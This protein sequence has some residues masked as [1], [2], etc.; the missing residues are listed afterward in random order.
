MATTTPFTPEQLVEMNRMVQE[1]IANALAARNS[2]TTTPTTTA[3]AED[4]WIKEAIRSDVLGT[5][6]PDY[7]SA[8]MTKSIVVE[9]GATI[10]R[11]VEIFIERIDRLI[12]LC[13][14]RA[15]VMVEQY[16]RGEA[17]VWWLHQV[18]TEERAKMKE[19]TDNCAAWKAA[20]RERFGI[21][22][23]KAQAYLA[24]TLYGPLELNA[25]K[26]VVAF[27]NERQLRLKQS[28]V[29]DPKIQLQLIWNGLLPPYRYSIAPPSATETATQFLDRL[30]QGEDSWRMAPRTQPQ[31]R[32]FIPNAGNPQ[33]FNTRAA[34][35]SN[36]VSGFTNANTRYAP[37][38]R[39]NDGYVRAYRQ[40]FSPRQGGFNR[41]GYGSNGYASSQASGRF[42][43][44]GQM[45]QQTAN[46]AQTRTY[47]PNPQAGGMKPTPTPTTT[48]PTATT[49][50]SQ[51]RAFQP[52]QRSFTNSS[53]NLN[54]LSRPYIPP[55]NNPRNGFHADEIVW[56]PEAYFAEPEDVYFTEDDVFDNQDFDGFMGEYPELETADGMQADLMPVATF[57]TPANTSR[58]S[59]TPLPSI[60]TD[61]TQ[62]SHNGELINTNI[63]SNPPEV[64][65]FSV[66]CNTAEAFL[67][68][69]FRFPLTPSL[70]S[71]PSVVANS[72]K[73]TSGK[74]LCVP[75]PTKCE[76]CELQFPSAR[77]CR[78]HK[79]IHQTE[80]H[81]RPV[82]EIQAHFAELGP[83]HPSA[84]TT[85]ITSTA[86]PPNGTG[87]EYKSYTYLKAAMAIN[88]PNLART[89]LGCLD[90]GCGISLIDA[91]FA[92]SLNL[93]EIQTRTEP[94]AVR[95]IGGAHHQSTTFAKVKLYFPE[96]PAIEDN[97]PPARVA[98]IERDLHIVPTL[99]CKILIGNDVSVPEHFRID[100]G[101]QILTIGSCSDITIPVT[102]FRSPPPLLIQAAQRITIP[103][104]GCGKIPIN[105]RHLRNQQ[106]YEFIPY[107]AT[108]PITLRRN[109]GLRRAFID[110]ET[111]AI[112]IR[113][114]SPKPLTITK[115]APLGTVQPVTA[116]I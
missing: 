75:K 112:P 13:K 77:Q 66:D 108:S 99:R 54:G 86:A 14:D 35:V 8:D 95:G 115:H 96:K 24:S 81:P 37:A 106:D 3:K 63:P 44:P 41:N 109:G 116:E 1:G 105:T 7:I 47:M 53:S 49:S 85:F 100:F 42:A 30:R 23:A 43:T 16:L 34:G 52:Q 19:G 12:E 80:K 74:T 50:N 11:D 10:I 5:F 31:V 87:L 103:A 32:S 104:H 2:T 62:L 93:T 59:D 61:L 83:S 73:N 88:D 84:N 4:H 38:V 33:S 68:E 70:L 46:S 39:T 69:S 76:E 82:P 36:M 101:K 9:H 97:N 17:H 64:I 107:L 21:N 48:F 102:A 20:L 15:A 55:M 58:K 91:E 92:S 65:P 79:T 111:A 60:V 26:S 29:V 90:G 57:F 89:F 28:G 72:K 94:L 6:E 98:V 18:S 40:P 51:Q 110:A 67:L 45:Q 56:V 78:R 22:A 27:F 113:N 25:G 71:L 114:H